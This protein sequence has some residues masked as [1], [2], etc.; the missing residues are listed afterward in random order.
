VTGDVEYGST[1][2]QSFIRHFLLRVYN[3]NGCHAKPVSLTVR[4]TVYRND[5]FNIIPSLKEICRPSKPS[6][7]RKRKKVP[8]KLTTLFQYGDRP[9]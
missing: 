8:V 7:F 2:P 3:P 1:C 4:L 5:K 6:V 9:E